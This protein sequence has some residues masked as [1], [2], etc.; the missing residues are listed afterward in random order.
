MY[1]KELGDVLQKQN[2]VRASVREYQEISQSQVKCD[3][4]KAQYE[5][6][7]YQAYVKV[8]Q[9]FHQGLMGVSW[10]SLEH[11][12]MPEEPERSNH[13]EMVTKERISNYKPSLYERVFKK[14][15][16]RLRQLKEGLVT[17]KNRDIKDYYADV[18]RYSQ[19]KDKYN[20][21]QSCY[22]RIESHDMTTC[23]F[24]LDKMDPFKELR[25]FGI[26]VTFKQVED[27]IEISLNHQ[28]MKL[29]PMNEKK[30]VD[31]QVVAKKMTFD[32]S[33]K[34]VKQIMYSTSV[35]A[36]RETFTAIPINKLIVHSYSH[37]LEE[38]LLKVVYKRELFERL[39]LN[40]EDP[41]DLLQAFNYRSHFD[42]LESR[43]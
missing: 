8:I 37:H 30:L 36:A 28:L 41:Y 40:I 31:N 34:L 9:S 25:D 26:E 1:W 7:S 5:V 35:R 21:Y 29:L 15:S 24:W 23:L 10:K 43:S 33:L 17:A 13:H 19:N 4:D 14:D 3:K 12:A 16:E 18:E 6:A 20:E 2:I 38:S 32:A 22:K 42:I 39:N 11:I 27:S